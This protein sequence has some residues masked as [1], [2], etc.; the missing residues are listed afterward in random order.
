MTSWKTQF[1]GVD[2]NY[3]LR[4][5]PVSLNGGDCFCASGKSNC[6]KTPIFYDSNGTAIIFPGN[7]FYEVILQDFMN[8]N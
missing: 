7:F 6:T 5:S 4:S 3:I 2:E 1:T 8:K